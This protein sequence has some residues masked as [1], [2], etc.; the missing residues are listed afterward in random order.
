MHSGWRIALARH[1]VL[2]HVGRELNLPVH[3]M[4]SVDTATSTLVLGLRWSID[5]LEE[6][7]R[8]VWPDS[9]DNLS[10]SQGWDLK[11]WIYCHVV[12]MHNA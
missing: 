10:N 3:E 7:Q 8:R 9:T 11:N 5:P 12:S 2:E 6:I 4:R 1:L